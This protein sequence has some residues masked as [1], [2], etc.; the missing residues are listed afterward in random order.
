MAKTIE[1]LFR[2]LHHFSDLFIVFLYFLF[3]KKTKKEKSFLLIT[4]YVL[5]DFILD[6][7]TFSLQNFYNIVWSFFTLIEYSIFT[8]IIWNNI[9]NRSF[10]KIAILISI[11]FI[12]FAT[13]FNT[14][15]NF[16]KTDSIPIG[17]ETI[18]ILIF[19]FYYLYE[20]TNSADNL[21]IYNKYQFWLVVG[22]MIYLAG[23]FFVFIFAS[24]MGDELLNQY[25]FLTNCFYILMI[26]FFAVAFFI[27]GKKPKHKSNPENF[28]PYL[29]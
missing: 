13:I 5:I 1:N 18:F 29:N 14:V 25:W 19:C 26:T 22:F 3:L 20:Q 4:I 23:S 15:T 12:V 16:K 24:G 2:F 8:Y 28:R 27:Y 7:F 6:I 9:R 21:F 10:K 17:I 11:L